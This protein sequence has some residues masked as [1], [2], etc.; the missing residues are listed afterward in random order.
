M[1]LKG[2]ILSTS[3]RK[4]MFYNYFLACGK[5]FTF[6]ISGVIYF[7]LQV[8]S[9]VKKNSSFPLKRVNSF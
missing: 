7:V 2:E 9:L 5:C 8:I 3:I 1:I 6:R 4:L